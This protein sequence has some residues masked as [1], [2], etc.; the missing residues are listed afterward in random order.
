[1]K[2]NGYKGEMIVEPGADYYTD[3]NGFNSVEKTWRHLGIQMGKTGRNWAQV[4][5][6]WA[7][8]NAPPY[9]LF[10]NLTPN[11]DEWK[12]WSGVPLE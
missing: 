6:Y 11:P 7:G 2:K 1:M 4:Q 10:G 9:F 12:L 8:Q 5:N 3:Q